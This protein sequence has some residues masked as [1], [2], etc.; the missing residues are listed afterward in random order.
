PTNY[1]IFSRAG[2]MQLFQRT[3]WLVRDFATAGAERASDPIHAD[4]DERA[5]CLLESATT[6]LNLDA[7]LTEGWHRLEGSCRWTTQRFSF[8]VQC[9]RATRS[10]AELYLRFLIPE[11]ILAAR[12]GV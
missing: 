7:R 3:G 9:P 12:P 6:D 11:A 2:L 4:H 1:W 10:T 8:L 5:F